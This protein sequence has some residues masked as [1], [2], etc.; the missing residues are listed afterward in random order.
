M[1]IVVGYWGLSSLPDLK[2]IPVVD[3]HGVLIDFLY[4]GAASD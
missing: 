4:A 2:E 3:A 1:H